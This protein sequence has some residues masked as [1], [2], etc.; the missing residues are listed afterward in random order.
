MSQAEGGDGEDHAKPESVVVKKHAERGVVE[1]V[2]KVE[3]EAAGK[4]DY[5]DGGND[6]RGHF[7]LAAR[8]PRDKEHKD[9]EDD[10]GDEDGYCGLLVFHGVM[11]IFGNFIEDA[12]LAPVLPIGWVPGIEHDAKKNYEKQ[13]RKGGREYI[14]Y[15]LA[16]FNFLICHHILSSFLGMLVKRFCNYMFT[17]LRDMPHPVLNYPNFDALPKPRQAKGRSRAKRGR[18]GPR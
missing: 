14:G 3:N 9:G 2:G 11:K 6:P 18:G 7:V 5:R 17:F 15:V 8:P 13:H 16:P 10:L 12:K 1:D 4:R